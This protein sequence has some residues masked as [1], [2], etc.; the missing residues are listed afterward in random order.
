MQTEYKIVVLDHL[1]SGEIPAAYQDDPAIKRA[2][3]RVTYRPVLRNWRQL[4][5]ESL[6]CF[7]NLYN[8]ELANNYWD[9]A[10]QAHL[11]APCGELHFER[12]WCLG[13]DGLRV[14]IDNGV[15]FIG[16]IINWGRE[17]FDW[18]IDY[19]QVGFFDWIGPDM[20]RADFGE[21]ERRQDNII[22][23]KYP[24]YGIFGHWLLDIVPQLTAA[25]YMDVPEGTKFVFNDLT[26]W[27]RGLLDAAGATSVESYNSRLTHHIGLRMPTG[28]KNGYA[29]SQPI[30]ALA[31]GGLR[32]HFNHLNCARPPAGVDRL[33]VSRSKWAGQRSLADYEALE[34]LMVSLGFTIFHPEQHSL[35]DQ[36]H[37]FSG[38]KIILGEDGSG[39]HT[40]MFSDPGAVLG[41]LMQANRRNLWHAGIC[42][43]MGHRLAYHELK[44]GSDGV[45]IDLDAIGA[46]ARSMIGASQS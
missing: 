31:W 11:I 43:T 24:G 18:W 41:V 15:V 30:N 33:F 34:R 42:H 2:L 39:L 44:Q 10:E 13:L 26:D 25:R 3:T 29:L 20:F 16:N 38:A 46:F 19:S 9:M 27:M 28:M 40:I 17:Y 4:R 5:D 22:M 1:V 12:I 14:D 6:F 8:S 32:A 35:Q 23:M 21:A 7:D 37:Y 36:A 45:K